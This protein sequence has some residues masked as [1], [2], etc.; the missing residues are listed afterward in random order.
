[1]NPVVTAIA[2]ALAISLAGNASLS[3]AWLH[4]RDAAIELRSQRDD[5]RADA[6]ACS[7]ATDDLADLAGKR[8]AAAKTAQAAAAKK[9]RAHEE[10]AQAILTMPPAVLG[11]VCASA[12]ARVDA[13]VKGRAAP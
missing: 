7:D 2:V 6:S 5:A 11:D 3:W 10:L 13:W 9:A 8:A 1:M 12:Q 4:A